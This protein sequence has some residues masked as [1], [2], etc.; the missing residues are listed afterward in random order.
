MS[1]INI[2]KLAQTI[3]LL[4]IITNLFRSTTYTESDK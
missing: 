4:F 1:S 2:K 3:F